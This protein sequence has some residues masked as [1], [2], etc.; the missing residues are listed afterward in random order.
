MKLRS[1]LS[2]NL[3]DLAMGSDGRLTMKQLNVLDEPDNPN[4]VVTKRYLDAKIDTSIGPGSIIFLSSTDTP[5]GFLKCNGAAVLRATYP[6]LYKKIGD[7]FSSFPAKGSGQ[8]WRHQYGINPSLDELD[9]KAWYKDT[10]LPA[11][12][13]FSQAIVTRN[14][15]YLIS[16]YSGSSYTTNIYTAPIDNN[17]A[18]GNWSSSSVSLPQALTYSQAVVIN[19]YVYL[20]GGYNGIF[21]SNVY[22]AVINADGTLGNFFSY[23]SL[24]VSSAQSQVI[25]TKNRIY[26]IAGYMSGSVSNRTFT[27]PIDA[28]GNIGIWLPGP[29]LP[30]ELYSHQAT[31]IRDRLYVFGGTNDSADSKNIYYGVINSDGTIDAWIED[32]PLPETI[33]SGSLVCSR[34]R[35]YL[36]G[37]IVKGSPAN[38]IYTALINPDGT[39]AGWNVSDTLPETSYGTMAF[40]TSM[41]IYVLAGYL[42]GSVSNRVNAIDFSGGVNDY[43]PY[44][45]PVNSELPNGTFR[46]PD[47]S[48]LEPYRLYAYMKY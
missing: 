2:S 5:A 48:F 33:H 14:R 35:V 1:N 6:D 12:N 22:R 7:S 44:Y 4:A 30:K 40:V 17:G 11:T 38:T 47:Y 36:I 15:V 18:L 19:N 16:R 9:T 25:V 26:L 31:V 45:S 41:S 39:L 10:S 24:P 37:G 28:S 27:A 3:T 46:L 42:N 13:A 21:R 20:L 43:S 34:N 8:P 32:Y 23:N 29:V